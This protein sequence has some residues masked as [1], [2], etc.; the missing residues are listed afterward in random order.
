MQ[1]FEKGET[2]FRANR[3]PDTLEELQSNPFDRF[4][5]PLN[6]LSIVV[7]KEDSEPPF[8]KNMRVK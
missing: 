1:V 4:L 3:L 7:P 5:Y 8:P 2:G 6:D